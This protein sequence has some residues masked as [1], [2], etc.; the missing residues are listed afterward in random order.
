M[1]VL[2]FT[3]RKKMCNLYPIFIKRY[4]KIICKWVLRFN[5]YLCILMSNPQGWI[6]E[7]QSHFSNATWSHTSEISEFLRTR[8]L[9]THFCDTF[10]VPYK[11]RTNE[12]SIGNSYGSPVRRMTGWSSWSHVERSS[13]THQKYCWWFRNPA[14]QLRLV[15]YPIIYRCLMVFI[16]PR[17]LFGISEP[18]NI[19]P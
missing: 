16:H 10:L 4:K 8:Q 7:K 13:T 15:V 18:S 6:S 19:W 17:W 9:V 5:C 12:E 14:N 11:I 2:Y 3:H 1:A